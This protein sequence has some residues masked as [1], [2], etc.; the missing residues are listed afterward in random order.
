MNDQ[1]PISANSDEAITEYFTGLGRFIHAFAYAEGSLQEAL[2]REA[3][4]S[5]AAGVALFSS[6]RVD[7]AKDMIN[8]LADASGRER[9]PILARAFAQLTE[10]ARARNDIVHFGATF[11]SDGIQVS[12]EKAAHIP[13]R[14]RVRPLSPAIMNALAED[15]SRI[16]A[17]IWLEGAARLAPTETREEMADHL[18]FLASQPWQYKPPAPPP[19]TKQRRDNPPKRMPQ[20]DA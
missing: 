14:L 8:R 7:Q 6:V 4:V 5:P 11:Q 13:E 10:I 18:D 20:P 15:V 3:G 9:S 2:C 12:N 17:M 19:P 1:P 16:S